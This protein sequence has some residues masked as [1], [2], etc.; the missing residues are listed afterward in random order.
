M[1]TRPFDVFLFK[2]FHL[3][4]VAQ[5]FSSHAVGD[6]LGQVGPLETSN[7]LFTVVWYYSNDKVPRFLR[8]FQHTELEHTP[9]ATFPNRL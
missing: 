8:L 5:D 1:I 9:F 3:V 4:P 6:S 2:F 7:N